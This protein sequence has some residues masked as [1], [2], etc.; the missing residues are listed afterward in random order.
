MFLQPVREVLSIVQLSKWREGFHYS[1]LPDNWQIA[2]ANTFNQYLLV[3][4][5]HFIQTSSAVRH[6]RI[7]HSKTY[8]TG[9]FWLCQRNFGLSGFA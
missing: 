2:E 3:G 5:K 8:F 1:R 4:T 6:E 9:Q 7:W